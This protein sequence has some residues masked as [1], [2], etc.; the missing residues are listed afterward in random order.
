MV[1]VDVDIL[2]N[3][4]FPPVN[5]G[6][7]G[8]ILTAIRE[9]G[10]QMT[11]LQDTVAELVADDTEL[12]ADV[13]ALVNIIND[14]PARI[15]AAVA[16]ALTEAGV[17][18]E[19]IRTSLNAID[20]SVKEAIAAAKAVLPTTVPGGG[21]TTTGGDTNT[22]TTT[23]GGGTDT[24]VGGTG[25]DTVT[26]GNGSDTV[27]AGGGTDTT[28]GG[29]GSDTVAAGDGPAVPPPSSGGSSPPASNAV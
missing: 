23:G 13:T 18:D 29:Q 22:D 12:A 14:I 16:S 1:K 9:L 27:A 15:Q 19:T 11:T 7:S 3:I 26:G 25:D 2:V 20:G 21:D 8:E 6:D 10:T 28:V 17:N 24:I 5:P 4:N